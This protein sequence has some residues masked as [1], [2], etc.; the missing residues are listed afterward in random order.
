MSVEATEWFIEETQKQ[1]RANPNQSVVLPHTIG[2][3]RNATVKWIEKAY[4][5]FKS[6]PDI[7]IQVSTTA[8]QAYLSRSLQ[9]IAV[10]GEVPHKHLEFVV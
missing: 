10:M 1:L 3:L 9:N 6:R 4:N 8:H 2:P 5:Y 7:I